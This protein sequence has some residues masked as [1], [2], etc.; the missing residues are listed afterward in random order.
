MAPDDPTIRLVREAQTGAD[1]TLDALC[2]AWLPT[3]VGWAARMGGPKVDAEDA[4]HDVFIV[5]FRRLA[6]VEHAAAFPRWLFSVT[7]R[8]VA[9]HRRRAWVRRWMPG[10]LPERPDPAADPAEHAERADLADRVWAAISALPVHHREVV[11]LCDIEERPDREAA[12]ILGIPRNTVKSRL[13]RARA[14]L[15]E[16]VAELSP[17]ADSA[18]EPLG[19]PS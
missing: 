18:P 2:H 3:V 1:G 4:A 13:R 19:G 5:V 11:V 7:R 10:A 12:E 14:S 6:D 9:A 8:V 16:Q 17:T 15:R